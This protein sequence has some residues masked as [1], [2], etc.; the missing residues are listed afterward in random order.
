MARAFHKRLNDLRR[1]AA[2]RGLPCLG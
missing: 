1:I 2:V